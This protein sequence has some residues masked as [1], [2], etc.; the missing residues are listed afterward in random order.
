MI[1]F[2]NMKLTEKQKKV[3]KNL[4]SISSK[5]GN[6]ATSALVVDANNDIIDASESLVASNHDATAHA[7]LMLVAKIGQKKKSNYTPGLTM[8]TVI[9]PCLMCLSASSQAG[10]KQ[11]SY[12][13]PAKKFLKVN[14]LITDVNSSIDKENIAENFSEPI[15]LIHLTE[16]EE[17]FS[18]LFKEL[19]QK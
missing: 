14:P 8:I 11:I 18:K 6:L 4:M 1:K 10:Y 15:K 5:K 7:E 12:I 13:I 2:K 16:Y 17:E 9:E 19:S 3:L